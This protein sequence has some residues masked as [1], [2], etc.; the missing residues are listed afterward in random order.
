MAMNTTYA[1]QE[2]SRN[3]VD[4]LE[5]ATLIE[6]GAPWCGFCRA[7]QPLIEQAFQD[8]P[9]I[10]HLKIEDG[11]G[12]RLGRSFKVKLWP[13]LIFFRNGQEVSRLVRPANTDDI[14]QGLAGIDQ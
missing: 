2:P 11:S 4:A 12:R 5:G 7:A 3:E 10:R 8:H 1:A 13:T 14:R 9:A 6:F